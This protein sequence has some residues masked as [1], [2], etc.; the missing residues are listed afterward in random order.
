[1]IGRRLQGRYQITAELGR[2]GTGVVYKAED[3]LLNRPVAI[4]VLTQSGL[5]DHEERRQLLQEAQ[6][7]ARLDHPHTITL[8]L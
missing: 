5:E 1:M 4:K 6:A 7:A 3:Q 2:G 8:K